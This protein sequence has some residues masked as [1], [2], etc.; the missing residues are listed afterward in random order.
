MGKKE[1][2]PA[3]GLLWIDLEMTGLDSTHDVILEMALVATDL[4]LKNRQGGPSVVIHQPEEALSTMDAWCCKHHAASGLLDAVRASTITVEKAE[5]LALAFVEQ[6]CSSNR[7]LFAGNTIYQDRAFL[8]RYM[9]RLNA[10]GHYRLVDV[11]SVKELVVAWYPNDPMARFKKGKAHRALEDVYE[12]IEEL[13]HY[14]QN[15]FV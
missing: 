3:C 14:R 7:L 15:F 8:A 6:Y 13:C 2:N 10:K 5:E 1:E 9:P 11:S 4:Q 12:S